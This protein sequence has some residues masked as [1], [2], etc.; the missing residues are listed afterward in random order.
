[1]CAHNPCAQPHSKKN[2]IISTHQP[3]PSSPAIIYTRQWPMRPPVKPWCKDD[4][5]K[6]QKL[7]DVSKVN[8]TNTED[9]DNIESVRHTYFREQKVDNFRRNF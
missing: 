1:V 9:T 2:D 8:I 4:K 5:N 3:P 6:L 7:I